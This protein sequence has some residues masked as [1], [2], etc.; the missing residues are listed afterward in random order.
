MLKRSTLS[1]SSPLFH[2]SQ[3]SW[4][5]QIGGWGGWG[6]CWGIQHGGIGCWNSCGRWP[7]LFVYATLL[8]PQN[9][10]QG[11]G[12]A[13]CTDA[14]PYLTKGYN[15][16]AWACNCA[17]PAEPSTGGL[18]GGCIGSCLCLLKGGAAGM[19]TAYTWSAATYSLGWGSGAHS[20]LAIGCWK[21]PARLFLW[22]KWGLRKGCSSGGAW[23]WALAVVAAAI[24][25][26]SMMGGQLL[27][28]CMLL[29]TSEIGILFWGV[30][31]G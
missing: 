26:L 19:A 16:A 1:H 5:I 2:P 31:R 20:G 7:S 23:F 14:G 11:G 22:R 28:L 27:S 25:I 9:L 24:C 13:G 30:W 3:L 17:I 21:G 6:G 18:G 15:A 10:L 4:C 8:L 12:G 29:S